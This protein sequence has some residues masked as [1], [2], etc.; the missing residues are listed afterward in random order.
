MQ[1]K[2]LLSP[3]SALIVGALLLGAC[4]PAAV[5]T[6][7]PETPQ[8]IVQTVVV[9]G[10]SVVQTVVV[11]GTPQV[12]TIVVT[13]TPPP[14]A[15]KTIDVLANW[16]GA[17]KDAFQKVLDGFTAKT[18]I[19]VNYESSRNL[20]TLVRTRV[21][22]GSPPDV[23]M[24]PR[25]GAIAEFAAS[26]WLIPL[27][28]PIGKEVL[29]PAA[30][31]K[32]FGPAYINLGKVN[33]TL[34][35][36]I[37][38]TDSKSTFWY[39]PASFTALGVQPPKTLDDLFVIADKYKAAG[40]IPFAAGGKDGWTLTD[41][42]EN[43][44]LRIAGGDKYNDLHIRHKIAWTDPQVIT[45]LTD[46][47]RFFQAGYMPGGPQGVVGTGFTDSIA[48]VFGPNPVAE[49]YYE[50]GFVGTIAIGQTNT[51]LK[52]GIDINF[53]PFPQVDPAQGDPVEG[54]GDF[55]IMFKDTPEG[56]AFM[57]YLASKEGGEIFAGTNSISPNLL[58]D[59]SKFSSSL[60]KTEFQQLA[61]AKVFVFDGSDMAPSAFGG[62]CEFSLL[63]EL[64]Q[65]PKDVKRIAQAL[66]DCAK[67][68]Y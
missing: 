27:D 49:M 64:V 40:K 63:Q 8:T 35:G 11:P 21:A 36:L 29:N 58:V 53:F 51:A 16:G 15:A 32:A 24:E 62:G 65:N 66:E 38:K 12:Q 41:Y 10:T 55:A 37:F 50:G 26:N 1:A 30:L 18:G 28:E 48:Q 25:P 19:Q 14:A 9:A 3:I 5:P 13:A 61:N 2:R 42:F 46:F 17:E 4:A 7:A 20:E 31:A 22:G 52:P 68:S 54:G 33:G 34:F 44:Y 45:A 23:V 59:P 56:R 6:A 57:Q 60:R 39:K 67:A 43:L 47:T